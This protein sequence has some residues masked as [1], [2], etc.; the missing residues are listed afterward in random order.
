[1]S[2]Q[3]QLISCHVECMY[4]YVCVCVCVWLY[5]SDFELGYAPSQIF[6]F[7]RL[8]DMLLSAV[9]CVY[10]PILRHNVNCSLARHILLIIVIIV[11][12][13]STKDNQR[14]EN[15][16]QFNALI[17]FF[18]NYS[19]QCTGVVCKTPWLQSVNTSDYRVWPW[20]LYISS[21]PRYLLPSQLYYNKNKI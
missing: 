5:V 4:V 3:H 8:L 1:V 10:W 11:Y 7:I 21:Q 15:R 2:S 6:A 17:L 18:S 13:S 12:K 19:I 16:S 9:R 20:K 14:W